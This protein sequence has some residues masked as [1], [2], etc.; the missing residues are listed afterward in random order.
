MKYWHSQIKDVVS[1]KFAIFL[2][3]AKVDLSEQEKVSIKEAGEFSKS[4]SAELFQTSAKDGTG[5]IELFTEIANKLN[6]MS[7]ANDFE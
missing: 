7:M 2:V 4:L 5:V 1:S 6:R 3:A